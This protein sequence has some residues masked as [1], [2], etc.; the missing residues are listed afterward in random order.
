MLRGVE[1]ERGEGR[2]TKRGTE[3]TDQILAPIEA[4]NITAVLSAFACD[5]PRDGLH[6]DARLEIG[7]ILDRPKDLFCN[8]QNLGKDR[9]VVGDGCSSEQL[10]WCIPLV[11]IMA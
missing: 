4:Q 9:D 5:C 6:N 2:N 7:Y 1:G 11:S 10:A 8:V 3:L